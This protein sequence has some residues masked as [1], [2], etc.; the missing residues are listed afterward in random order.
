[1]S[2]PIP[3]PSP[4]ANPRAIAE[5]KSARGAETHRLFPIRALGLFVNL[6]REQLSSV[7]RKEVIHGK[8][9][10]KARKSPNTLVGIGR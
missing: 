3:T 4:T 9:S 2:A 6:L 8:S 10:R 7:G 5:K 1:M